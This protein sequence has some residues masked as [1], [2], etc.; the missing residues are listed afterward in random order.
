MRHLHRPVAARRLMQLGT[1]EGAMVLYTDGSAVDTACSQLQ[2]AGW[3]VAALTATTRFQGA[4][5]G[6]VPIDVGPYETASD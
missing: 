5:Y 4:C 2:R 1:L 3:A 6:T